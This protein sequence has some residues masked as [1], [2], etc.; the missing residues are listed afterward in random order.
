MNQME[1]KLESSVIQANN[2]KN[3]NNNVTQLSSTNL[4][5]LPSQNVSKYL[6]ANKKTEESNN[7]SKE[8]VNYNFNYPYGVF[9][10]KKS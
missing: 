5:A 4:Q 7:N 6:I 9:T 1:I 3:N 2:S 10:L 8:E